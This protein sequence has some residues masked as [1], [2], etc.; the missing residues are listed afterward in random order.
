MCLSWPRPFHLV[1]RSGWLFG[2]V[3]LV[4]IGWPPFALRHTLA[5]A[6][7][8][9]VIQAR[10]GIAFAVYLL[11]TIVLLHACHTR[12]SRGLYAVSEGRGLVSV[13]FSFQR[14]L[15]GA[16]V[17]RDTKALLRR[18]DSIDEVRAI[19][20]HSPILNSEARACAAARRALRGLGA[21]WR[22]EPPAHAPLSLLNSCAARAMYPAR[23]GGTKGKLWGWKVTLRRSRPRSGADTG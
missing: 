18:L 16:T 7:L 9:W 19:V 22:D 8:Y 5:V 1:A 3:L 11:W 12:A 23:Y 4:L 13:H 14:D 17:V 6:G 15:P 2:I 20:L 10:F 21:E